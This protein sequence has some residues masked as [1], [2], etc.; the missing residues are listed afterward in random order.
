M[1]RSE[2]G[3]L[4][5]IG[6]DAINTLQPRTARNQIMYGIIQR[7]PNASVRTLL[8]QGVAADFLRY[9]A[10]MGWLRLVIR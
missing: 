1:T 3:L 10:R 8:R 2:E 7:Y 6:V 5:L 4:A 9:M